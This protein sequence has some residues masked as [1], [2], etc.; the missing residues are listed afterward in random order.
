MDFERLELEFVRAQASVCP[1]N[2]VLM[3]F[4]EKAQVPLRLLLIWVLMCPS[5]GQKRPRAVGHP[6]EEEKKWR[7]GSL[8]GEGPRPQATEEGGCV[9]RG[10][11]SAGGVFSVNFWKFMAAP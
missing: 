8:K 5:S 11:A 1:G 7:K 9:H 10:L 2:K 3:S 4:A 6:S